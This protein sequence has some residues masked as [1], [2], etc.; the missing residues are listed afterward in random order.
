MRARERV[1]IT[2]GAGFIGSH[3]ADALLTRGYGVRLLDNLD[4]QVHGKAAHFPSY[5]ARDVEAIRGDVR[6]PADVARALEGVSAVYHFAAAVGVGQ[7]MYQIE[8]YTDVN[9]RGTA[10]LLEALLEHPVRKL[11]VASSMSVYGEGQYRLGDRERAPPPRSAR[12]LKQ[13]DWEVRD[14]CGRPLEPV[15]TREDKTIDPQSI[16]ALSK[17]DQETMCRLYGR[18][19]DIPAVALRFFNVYGP[20]QALANPY[21]GVL[22][23]FAARYLNGNRPMI[24][25]DGLQKRDFVHV[26][27]LAQACVLALETDAAD[28]AL[29]IGSGNAYTIIEIARRL[30][31]VLGRESI[32]PQVSGRY[33]AGDIRNCYADIARATEVL[34]YRPRIALDDGLAELGEWLAQSESEDHGARAVSELEARGLVA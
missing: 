7:S 25:E 1:L 30:A 5:L 8:R 16:Y 4:A 2:G 19:Y 32:E 26:R 18:A 11:I 17:L 9:N 14:P 13:A 12:Q 24:F 21:T 22:A 29:N 27:D 33:R 28:V 15:P 10:V 34:G 20:R 3:V 6:N 31:R 23:N